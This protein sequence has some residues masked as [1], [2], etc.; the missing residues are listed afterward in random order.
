MSRCED[1]LL[2]AKCFRTAAQH[3]PVSFDDLCTIL[4]LELELGHRA[5]FRRRLRRVL[6]AGC[7]LPE[8]PMRH[9]QGRRRCQTCSL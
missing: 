5:A 9:K 2:Q 7:M 3:P 4:E 8:A 6:S 1:S